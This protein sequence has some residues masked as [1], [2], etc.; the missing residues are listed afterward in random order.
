[1]GIQRS[2]PRDLRED[3]ALKK[4][5]VLYMADPASFETM[6]RNSTPEMQKKGMEAWMHWMGAHK[7]SLVDGGAP[8][9]KT[10]RI[11]TT[12]RRSCSARTTRIFR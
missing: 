2:F 6:M 4:F 3:G 12:P 7:A 1:L 9:G 11:R 5:L 10:K 8:L